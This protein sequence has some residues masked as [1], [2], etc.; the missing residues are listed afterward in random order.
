VIEALRRPRP[1]PTVIAALVALLG[2]VL[3]TAATGVGLV[4]VAGLILLGLIWMVALKPETATLLVIFILYTNAAGVAVY[5]YG[6]PGIAAQAIIALLIA[7]LAHAI[8]VRRLPIVITPAVPWIAA[9]L[10]VQLLSAFASAYAQA[11]AANVQAFL[12]EGLVL[13]LLITNVVRTPGTL[14]RVT[15]VLLAAGA[16]LGSFSLIQ[17]LTGNASSFFSGGELAESSYRAFGPIRDPNFYA[18]IMVMLLPIGAVKSVT[19]RALGIRVVA[20]ACTAAIAMAILLSYSRGA[21]VGVVVV[22]IGM[23]FLRYVRFW[24]L[25]L[26]AV[27]V[28][29]AFAAFPN[30]ASRLAT[31]EAV[32]AALSGQPSVGQADRSVRSRT[33]E[34]L[35]ALRGFTDK[36]VLGVGPGQ[37]PRYYQSYAN[38]I[39]V[40]VHLAEREAHNLYLDLAAETG[41][42]GLTT[43]MT[44]IGVTVS[45]L[46][47]AR[48][49]AS[50]ARPELAHIAAAFMLALTGYVVTSLFLH[51]AFERYIWLILALSG[52]A[53]AVTLREVQ[54]K[55]P[56]SVLDVEVEDEHATVR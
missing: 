12:A 26:I 2:L 47:R 5:S 16:V 28:V 44:V 35:A 38:E 7:P 23:L 43:F 25:P 1:D 22:L 29:V 42:L 31:L 39:G 3:A 41:L 21:A 52:A 8:L 51:L 15:W 46:N 24:H 30:Y 33:I 4:L 6:L 14:G 50:L 32:G 45:Q 56:R 17:Q 19:E 27:T 54:P 37:F 55:R 9:F 10:I 18:Q 49:L 53:A 48:R 20:V 13:Y 11:A 34:N 36:P 40:D